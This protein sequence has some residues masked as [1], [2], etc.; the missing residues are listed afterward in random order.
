[1]SKKNP[2]IVAVA[3]NKVVKSTPTTSMSFL[4]PNA[5]PTRPIAKALRPI[6]PLIKLEPIQMKGIAEPVEIWTI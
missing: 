4:R 3:M 6:T 1:M 2:P 5:N